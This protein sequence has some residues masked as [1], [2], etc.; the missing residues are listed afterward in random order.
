MRARDDYKSLTGAQKAALLLMS[1]GEESAA[2]IFAL[3]HDDEIKEISQTM[4]N[5]GTV[6]STVIEPMLVLITT[7]GFCTAPPFCAAAKRTRSSVAASFFMAPRYS[8]GAY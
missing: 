5:L 4:A 2:K 7:V 3:M 6:S 8:T 1:V